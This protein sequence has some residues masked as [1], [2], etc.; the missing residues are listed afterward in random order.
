MYISQVTA[1]VYAHGGRYITRTSE[2]IPLAGGWSRDRVII[3]E[4]PDLERLTSF[5]QSREYRALAKLR[6]ESTH[7]R[8][9]ALLGLGTQP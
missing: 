8:S 5:A 4:F 9:I 3:I 1:V 7:T 2:V 6:D